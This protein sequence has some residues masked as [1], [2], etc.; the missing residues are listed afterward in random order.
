MHHG[1]DLATYPGGRGETRSFCKAASSRATFPSMA[2]CP[3]VPAFSL[4]TY[5]TRRGVYA[6]AMGDEALQVLN[7]EAVRSRRAAP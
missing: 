4:V 7:L 5:V 2:S 3:F 1:Y 6:L